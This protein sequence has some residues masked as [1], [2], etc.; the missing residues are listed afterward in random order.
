MR[1]QYKVLSEKYE[2]VQEVYTTNTADSFWLL[3]PIRDHFDLALVDDPEK[4]KKLLTWFINEYC[5]DIGINPDNYKTIDKIMIDLMKA[6]AKQ[7]N[8]EIYWDA[9][10]PSFKEY[11]LLV[12]K[13][14]YDK[15]TLRAFTNK[16]KKIVDQ[17]TQATGGDWDIEGLIEGLIAE[18]DRLTQHKYY[19][20]LIGKIEE[21][22][23]NH[24]RGTSSGTD[25]VKAFYNAIPNFVAWL[26]DD[27]NA[28]LIQRVVP[29]PEEAENNL[30]TLQ[31]WYID[32]VYAFMT[33]LDFFPEDVPVPE[34]L[35]ASQRNVLIIAVDR[36]KRK[37]IKDYNAFLQSEDYKKAQEV[38][39][40]GTQAT[41]GDWDIEGLT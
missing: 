36:A 29:I 34:K 28:R 19:L 3:F 14:I 39:K 23:S 6:R 18:S 2:Q 21:V 4:I 13:D 8:A 15:Y 33:D 5:P 17:G 20:N 9:E 37:T 25:T 12:V 11:Q 22:L 40:Q 27:N 16:G 31:N 32:M 35:T 26:K 41:G 38:Y 7:D 1:T 24:L 10:D 30:A